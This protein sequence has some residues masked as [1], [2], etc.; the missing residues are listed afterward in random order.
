MRGWQPCRPEITPNRTAGKG[1]DGCRGVGRAVDGGAGLGDGLSRQ[2]GHHREAEDIR[3]ASLVTGHAKR[4]VALQMF[5]RAE[6]FL[7]RQPDILH[8]DVVL[9]VEPGAFR[10]PDMPQRVMRPGRP[11]PRQACL[12]A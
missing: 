11:R 10:A 7:M 5:D 2:F 9:L 1:G 6:I 8:R 3:G 4:G 12:A